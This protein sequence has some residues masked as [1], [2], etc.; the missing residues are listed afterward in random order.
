MHEKQAK[1]A[2]RFGLKGV[3][4]FVAACAVTLAVWRLLAPSP[5]WERLRTGM[6]ITEVQELVGGT[7]PDLIPLDRRGWFETDY[8]FSDGH[9]LSII[10]AHGLLIRFQVQNPDDRSTQ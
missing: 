8:E 9:R 6:T 10:Y 2:I 1:S 7:D 3:F 5:V 4:V